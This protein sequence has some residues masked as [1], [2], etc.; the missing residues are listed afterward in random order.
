MT[1]A[2]VRPG[3]GRTYDWAKDHVRVLCSV[4]LSEG[5]VTL[6]EDR[7]KPGFSLARHHHKK[8]IEVFYVLGGAVEFAFDGETVLCETGTTIS[9][10]PGVRHA[11]VSPGGAELLTIFCPGGFDA[12]LD[13]LAAMTESQYADLALMKGLSEKYDIFEG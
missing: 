10:P 8:M 11:V 2:I 12:Y 6:V 5:K 1:H 7:L 9:V 3:E 13:E 4:G